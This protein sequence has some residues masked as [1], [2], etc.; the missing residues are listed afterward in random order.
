[1]L[2]TAGQLEHHMSCYRTFNPTGPN[3]L[4]RIIWAESSKQPPPLQGADTEDT[5]P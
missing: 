1:M 5:E 3:I 4:C 2:D